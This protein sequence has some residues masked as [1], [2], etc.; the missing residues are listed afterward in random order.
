L[1]TAPSRHTD[2]SLQKSLLCRPK[3]KTK[4]S[5]P[6]SQ[7]LNLPTHLLTEKNRHIN[8]LTKTRKTLT[9]ERLDTDGRRTTAYNSGLAIFFVRG[10]QCFIQ[11]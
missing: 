10:R 3:R 4:K 5:F 11:H 1:Q 6:A 9:V 7:K 8:D 2:Q